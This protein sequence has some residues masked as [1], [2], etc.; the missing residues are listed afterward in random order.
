VSDAGALRAHVCI[1]GAGRL[2][3]ALALLLHEARDTGSIRVAG[4]HPRAP[5]HPVFQGSPARAEYLVGP[6]PLPIGTSALLLAVPDRALPDVVLRIARDSEL[7]GVAALHLSGAL[8][9]DALAPLREAGASVGT[10][11]PLASVS[12]APDAHRRLR[13]VAWGVE[14]RGAAL[15]LAEWVVAAAGGWI[16][17]V[18]PGAKPLYHAAAVLASN[19]VVALLAEAEGWMARAG[20]PRA[21][22]RRALAL[23]AGGAAAAVGE[24]GPAAALTGPVAR[25]DAAT[26]ELHLARLSPDERRLY[27]VLGERAVTLAR[28]GG[29]DPAVAARLDQRFRENA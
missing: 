28:A 12:R 6:V 19:Y 1:V 11:H 9:A 21:E 3:L 5:D 26:V 8:G 4:R 2:G 15:S 14:A 10:A 18:A 22:A 16:L 23:L 17:P 7:R 24:E 25:G 13:G 27:S 29:L 20:V